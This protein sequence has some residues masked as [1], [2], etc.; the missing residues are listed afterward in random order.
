MDFQRGTQGNVRFS[1]VLGFDI[2]AF[3]H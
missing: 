3:M 2:V 1:T